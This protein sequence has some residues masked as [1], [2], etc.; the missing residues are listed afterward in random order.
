[1]AAGRTG[2]RNREIDTAKLEQTGQIHRYGRVHR[3]EDGSASAHSRI[4]VLTHLV[5]A[6]DNGISRGVIAEQKTDHIV[7]EIVL[8]ELGILECL[9]S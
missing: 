1:M 4:L 9:Q 6:L 5:N 3:L 7:V 2:T 8:I